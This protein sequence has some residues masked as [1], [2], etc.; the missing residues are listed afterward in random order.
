ML[1]LAAFAHILDDGL[2]ERWPVL[3]TAH[4]LAIT[5][6]VILDLQAAGVSADWELSQVLLRLVEADCYLATILNNMVYDIDDFVSKPEQLFSLSLNLRA[7]QE[8]LN[9]FIE[10]PLSLTNQPCFLL[11][12]RL[13]LL[14]WPFRM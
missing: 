8:L 11:W 3:A 6:L 5:A 12:L 2:P 14:L 7:H 1:S 9:V 13:V 4:P 10:I